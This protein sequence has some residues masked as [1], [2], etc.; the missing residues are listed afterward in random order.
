MKSFFHSVV[1]GFAVVS[2]L[3]ASSASAS[4]KVA[5][6]LELASNS[7]DGELS[8]RDLA[9]AGVVF[10]AEASALPA[11]VA[12]ASALGVTAGTGTA[13]STLSGAAAVSA[14][15]AAI[16]APVAAVIGTVAGVALAPAVVGGAI[17]AGTAGVVAWGFNALFLDE[18]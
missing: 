11:A 2:V 6:T 16:G 10:G 13:I 1:F 12:G 5:G 9:K 17:I 8:V 7:L 18:D 3:G 14:T 15:S 4:P